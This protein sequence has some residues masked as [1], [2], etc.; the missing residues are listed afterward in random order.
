[1]N[2][3]IYNISMLRLS[4]ALIPVLAV[5]WIYIKWSLPVQT[6]LYATT[7]MLLQLI[8][9]G[10]ALIPIFAIRSW[11]FQ[12][13]LLCVMLLIAGWIS[14]RPIKT[15][16][17]KH[18]QKALLGL[19]IGCVFTLIIVTGFV[20]QIT[21]WDEPRYVIPL[22]GMIFSNAMNSVS[23]A[24]ERLQ[25]EKRKRTPFIEARNA[26]FKTSLLPTLNMFFA[27]G[28][29]SLPGMMTG[30]IL[31]GISPL[32]AVR[33]QIMVMCMVLGSAGISAAIYLLL[34]SEEMRSA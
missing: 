33:Y 25:S 32:I 8:A 21:P 19:S 15:Y 28:L 24:A 13:T 6:V 34:N 2:E 30:Q 3:S 11:I 22:A 26:A 5:M 23:L 31:A 9:I 27:V 1:M 18:F 17:K 10:F 20:L 12:C 16:R 4:M 14:I 7:R 29:V